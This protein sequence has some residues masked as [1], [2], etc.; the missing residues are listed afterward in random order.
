MQ[1]NIK[2]RIITIT[3]TRTFDIGSIIADS[4][5]FQSILNFIGW[6][7]KYVDSNVSTQSQRHM[8]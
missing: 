5:V 4:S 1:V 2:E 6:A 3:L 8:K 7:E